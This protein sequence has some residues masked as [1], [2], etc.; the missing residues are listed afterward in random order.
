MNKSDNDTLIQ[1]AQIQGF[2]EELSELRNEEQ[3]ISSRLFALQRRQNEMSM[4]KNSMSK[5]D[6]ALQ[7]QL[8]RLE[9]SSWLRS[10]VDP[11]K[12]PPLSQSDDD[13][14]A[15]VLDNCVMRLRQSSNRLET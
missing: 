8:Q 14:P 7:I 10:M 13:S 2:S 9:I 1:D 5:Y 15:E 12:M 11:D 3:Q 6:H 4:L